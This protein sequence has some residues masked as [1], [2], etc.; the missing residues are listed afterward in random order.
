MTTWLW[1]QMQLE[2]GPVNELNSV[3][4]GILEN[5]KM[6]DDQAMNII[7]ILRGI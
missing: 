5:P 1:W 6:T 7:E 2:A 3:I 4:I